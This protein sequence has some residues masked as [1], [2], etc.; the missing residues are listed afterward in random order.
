MAEHCQKCNRRKVVSYRV[1]PEE[2]WKIGQLLQQRCF[3]R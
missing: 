3:G 2:A 1:D